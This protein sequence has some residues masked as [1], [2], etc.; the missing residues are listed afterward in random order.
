MALVLTSAPTTEPVS[1]ADVKAHLRIEGAT[2]D[3]VLSSLLLTSRLHIETALGLAL[4]AQCWTLSLDDWPASGIVHLPIRPLL[5]VD[6]VRVLPGSG[7]PTLLHPSTYVV[8][9]GGW[10][11]RIVRA[12]GSEWPRPGKAANGIEID[13]TAGFGSAARDVPAPIRQA[14][15]ML[16]AHWYERRDPVEIGSRE[17]SIPGAVS[18]L[19]APFVE[20]R[21]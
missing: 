13:M 21:L 1:L 20:K 6:A 3:V 11:G 17:A 2:E 14:L 18:S 10:R 4:T 9:T 5:S 19:L 15:L 16:V 7:A 12:W 8:D